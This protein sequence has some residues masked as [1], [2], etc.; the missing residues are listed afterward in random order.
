MHQLTKE[1]RRTFAQRE[2]LDGILR[3][4]HALQIPKPKGGWVRAIRSSLGMRV[5]QLAKRAQLDP[6][7]VTRLEQNEEKS[8]ITLQSLQHL[9][10]ALGCEFVYA[11]VPLKPLDEL[12]RERAEKVFNKEREA[13][14]TTMELEAQGSKHQDSIRD[15]VLKAMIAS[16]LDKRLWEDE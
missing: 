6:S 11:L 8:T 12:V 7:T 10:D 15:D 13:A 9:A 5:E 3:P 2:A 4:L 16:K 1:Q 14:R